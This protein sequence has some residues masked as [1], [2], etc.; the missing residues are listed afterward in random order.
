MNNKTTVFEGHEVV[1]HICAGIDVHRDKVNVTIAKSE[2]NKVHF[3]YR[4]FW[5]VKSNLEEMLSWLISNGCTVVGMEST[6]KYWKPVVNVVERSIAIHLYNA[7]HIKNIPG[8]K[9][10]KK[11]SQWIAKIT[12]YELVTH[13]FIPDA[14]TRA[15]RD[16]VRYRKSV[17]ESRTRVRQQ[18]HDILTSC[19]IR[20][21]ICMSDIFGA[22]GRFLLDCIA[23]NKPLNK[24]ILELRLHPPLNKKVDEIY[25]ALEGFVNKSDRELLIMHL[26][27]EKRLCVLIDDI[28]AKLEK[29]VID[30]PEREDIVNRL[31]EVPGF[32]K[33]SATL[34]LGE[35]GIDLS[36]FPDSKHFSSWC[37]LAPGKKESA[38]KNLS[39]RIHVR[40]HYL[41][42][43]LVEVALASTRCKGTYFN[44]K[45]YELKKRKSTQKAVIAIARK[46]SI[47]IYMIIKEGKEFKELTAE[48]VPIE[49]KARDIRNIQ[50]IA[51]KLG[52]DAAFALLEQ[53]FEAPKPIS[54]E[55]K[56]LEDG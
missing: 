1:N 31:I 43:L 4:V 45:F 40:Q 26:E 25:E 10:D 15:T 20:I 11:D 17:V 32:S 21:A 39:G 3:H 22:S 30:T 7:R 2:G 23:H 44:S 27:E 34:L 35:L 9:T 13:S 29:M 50:R 55:S 49:A 8:K 51:T 16:F 19:G 52:K 33:R 41:R 53:V 5:T 18:V 47:A 28:E 12:R 24:Y 46:L 54:Q 14:K 36:S 48:Y 38:G 37:G 56:P 42:S 6:A